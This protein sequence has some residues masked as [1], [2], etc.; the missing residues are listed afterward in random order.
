M[1]V[2]VLSS[3]LFWTSDLWTH[4]PGS[5]GKKVT[6]DFLHLPSAVLA[7]IFI[8]KKI[9]PSL[10]LVDRQV[11]RILYTVICRVSLV[12]YC[13]SLEH[14]RRTVASKIVKMLCPRIAGIYEVNTD[15]SSRNHSMLARGQITSRICVIAPNIQLALLLQEHPLPYQSTQ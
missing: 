9:Q 4:Q 11:Y 10:S 15:D 2:Y 14:T 3:H 6:Q 5:H 8:A 1:C 7:L 12:R 13:N